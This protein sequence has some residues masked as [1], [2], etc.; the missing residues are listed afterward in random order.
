MDD[1]VWFMPAAAA[2]KLLQAPSVLLLF[3]L[4]DTGLL[5]VHDMTARQ[6]HDS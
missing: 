3:A 1:L 2:S 6:W 5:C 4:A